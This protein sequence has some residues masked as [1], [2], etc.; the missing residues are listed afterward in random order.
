MWDLA[1]GFGHK[2]LGSCQVN[3]PGCPLESIGILGGQVWSTKLRGFLLYVQGLHT[4]IW[5]PKPWNIQ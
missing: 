4:W 5:I 1:L 3:F 2:D